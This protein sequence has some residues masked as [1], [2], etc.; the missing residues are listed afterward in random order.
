MLR[1]AV[2]LRI[3][4]AI[5]EATGEV[6]EAAPRIGWLLDL[7]T[8]LSEDLMQQRWRPATFTTLHRGVDSLGRQL[9]ATAAVLAQRLG[10]K[11]HHGDH[12]YY[13]RD[14]DGQLA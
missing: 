8:Q 7:V 11:P 5:V 14:R 13:G 3:C 4:A 2:P 10:W 1:S 9:P 6:L 12:L